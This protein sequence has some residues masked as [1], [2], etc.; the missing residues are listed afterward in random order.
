[1]EV[2]YFDPHTSP[3][4]NEGTFDIKIAHRLQMAQSRWQ[5]TPRHLD[6]LRGLVQ[7]QSNQDLARDLR[8]TVRTVESHMTALM[9]RCDAPSRLSLVAAFWADL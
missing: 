7:G 1:M 6:V 3:P 4:S 5:L 2:T 9:Q 8:C